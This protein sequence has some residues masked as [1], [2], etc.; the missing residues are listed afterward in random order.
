M[1]VEG[2]PGSIDFLRLTGQR[3]WPMKIAL[4]LGGLV[5]VT[6]RSSRATTRAGYARSR[7]KH[8]AKSAS[9]PIPRNL[10]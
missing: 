3:T 10:P 9:R 2:R 6:V 7:R 5:V 1:A 8:Q 4:L